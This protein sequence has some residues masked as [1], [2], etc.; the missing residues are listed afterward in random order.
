MYELISENTGKIVAKVGELV[1]AKMVILDMKDRLKKL[2][3]EIV[4]EELDHD[5]NTVR[6]MSM[7]DLV[8]DWR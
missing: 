8:S 2:N 1:H 7:Y 4:I 5:G 6:V 3:D